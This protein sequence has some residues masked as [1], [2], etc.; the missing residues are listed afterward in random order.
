MRCLAHPSPAAS[1]ASLCRAPPSR[2][3]L[4]VPPASL[5]SHAR[6]GAESPQLITLRNGGMGRGCVRPQG[7]AGVSGAGPRPG[8][9]PTG[10]HH[11]ARSAPTSRPRAHGVPPPRRLNS[12]SPKCRSPPRAT[13]RAPAHR[14]HHRATTPQGCRPPQGQAAVGHRWRCADLLEAPV[15]RRAGK[16]ARVAGAWSGGSMSKGRVREES[17][18]NQGS[19][20]GIPG[21]SVNAANGTL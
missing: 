4:A 3:A 7:R 11:E 19:P 18:M 1:A 21:C 14:T 20:R 15:R 6:E 5:P 9:E 8:S 16:C 10:C 12:P 13:P 2:A 17:G